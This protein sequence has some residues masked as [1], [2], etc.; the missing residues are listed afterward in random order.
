MLT[1]MHAHMQTLTYTH[2]HT[3]THTYTHTHTRTYTPKWGQI[4]V[5][6]AHIYLGLHAR[7][8]RSV[9]IAPLTGLNTNRNGVE[10]PPR[11]AR[12]SAPEDENVS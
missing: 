5:T 9:G 4:C 2:T 6:I 8:A 11:C 1:L 7:A 3:Y 12:A 10:R